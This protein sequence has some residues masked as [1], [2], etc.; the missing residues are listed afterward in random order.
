MTSTPD[1][2]ASPPPRPGRRWSRRFRSAVIAAIVVVLAAAITAGVAE[3]AA[4]NG[5]VLPPSLDGAPAI[6]TFS[7]HPVVITL[8]HNPESYLGAFVKGVPTSYEPVEAFAD[9]T[10]VQPNIAAYYSGWF[11]KFR[12]AFAVEATTNGAI[13]LIQI[14]PSGVN[15]ATIVSGV[16]DTFLKVFA[17]QVASYGARTGHGI[18]ISF[19][20]EMNG[21]W[22]S[23]GYRHTPPAVFVAAW[24]H[25]VD[26]FRQQGAYDVTW[27]WTV[28]IINPRGGIPVPTPWWPGSSYVTWIGIDG[29]Y[30]KPSWT[31]APLFGPT[32]KA[33]RALSHHPIPILIAETGAPAANQ[34]AKITDLFAGMHVY[35]L[36]GFVWF[37]ARGVLD[38]R[39]NSAAAI[40]ALR[41]GA[42]TYI[43]FAS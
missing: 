25:I 42:K 8:P 29:Y 2:T 35:G 21:S 19:G 5:S 32:I 36:L 23:W 10:G 31:F 34:P 40:A 30:L 22:Y 1:V 9:S 43:R 6:G 17:T 7:R 28:N 3:I 11:E 15:L 38:W 4:P 26:L 14:D 41:R 12:S 39:L 27:L 20:H 13:P 18:I 16:Y 37:D 33:V 24:R